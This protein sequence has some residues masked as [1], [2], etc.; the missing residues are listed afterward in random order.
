MRNNDPIIP[1]VWITR[2]ALTKGILT[3]ENV[4]H[5]INTAD[6]MIAI[7]GVYSGAVFHKP[8]WH[9]SREEA[10]DRAGNMVL[11]K[12]ASIDK[13]KIKMH[14]L[15]REFLGGRVNIKPWSDS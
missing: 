9:T 4:R 12:L 1:R 5:C 7:D 13:Q 2:Y 8:H 11:K 15:L 10:L 14:R 3:A 6:T